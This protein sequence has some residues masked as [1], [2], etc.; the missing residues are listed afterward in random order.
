MFRILIYY[1][2][3]WYALLASSPFPAYIPRSSIAI[4]IVLYSMVGLEIVKRR[5]ALKSVTTDSSA[6]L[7][8]D[9]TVMPTEEPSAIP[10]ETSPSINH[11]SHGSTNGSV[12]T[13]KRSHSQRHTPKRS[14]L[15]FRQYILMP[16]FFFLALLTV[17]VAP[18]TNRVATF[19]DPAFASFPLLVTVG[20][21]GSLRGF[22]NGLV[23]IAVGMK[24][25]KRRREEEEIALRPPTTSDQLR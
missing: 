12:L 19:I 17:W 18:S 9:D 2:P 5:Q 24:S 25:W 6:L 3:I 1:V 13:A 21:T 22:W 16:L 10:V 15:S 20:V 8:L 11:A 4:I 14:S 23:F 7:D